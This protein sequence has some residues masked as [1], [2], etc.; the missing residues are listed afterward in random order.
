[1]RRRAFLE[2]AAAGV[3]GAGLGLPAGAAGQT[4]AAGRKPPAVK[5]PRLRPGSRVALVNPAGAT[6]DKQDI[7]VV[8]DRLAALDL[9]PVRG[10]HLLDRHGYLA[11]TDEARA[12]DINEMFADPTIDGIIAVRGGWGAARLLHLIDFDAVA[13]HPKVFMGYSDITTLLLAFQARTGLVTFHGPVGTSEWNDFSVGALRAI[14]FE[15]T[16]PTLS[17]P[18]ERGS[19]LVPTQ[20]R[21]R[22]ITAGRARGRLL[23]GNLTVLASLLGSPYVPDWTGSILFLEDIGEAIYRIDRLLTQLSLAGVLE[24]VAGVVFGKCTDCDPDSTYGSLTLPEVLQH[25]LGGLGI[26][27]WAGGMVGHIPLK[28][29]LPLGVEA[30][31]DTESATVRLLEPAVR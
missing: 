9:V 25:H 6:F 26:P 1:M 15:G 28:W 18:R 12:S 13:E 10:W 2:K 20:H 5:P 7:E 23:G 27:V 16:A 14:V 30:E 31:I 17:N 21:P 4:A 3:A 29:T 19:D 24:S 11:G 8:E 22:V